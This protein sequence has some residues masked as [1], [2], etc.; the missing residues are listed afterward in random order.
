[1]NICPIRTGL[2]RDPEY[3]VIIV[4]PILR[5]FRPQQ[6]TTFRKL[7]IRNDSE[8]CGQSYIEKGWWAGGED[9]AS[10]ALVIDWLDIVI[11]V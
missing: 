2:A 10:S 5:P 4:F 11:M 7:S 3:V 1:M 6:P 8:R 9:K